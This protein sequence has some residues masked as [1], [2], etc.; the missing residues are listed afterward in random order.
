VVGPPLAIPFAVT[1]PSKLS[2]RVARIPAVTRQLVRYSVVRLGV[3]RCLN[4]YVAPIAPQDCS[5]SP[6]PVLVEH[7]ESPLP[8]HRWITLSY[9]L[10]S[11]Y[12]EQASI[13]RKK[14]SINLRGR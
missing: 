12:T 3:R 13:G 11:L 6:T 10:A 9:V 2:M 14:K 4:L 1:G 8:K 5:R 7:R